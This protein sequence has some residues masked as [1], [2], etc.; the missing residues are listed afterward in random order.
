MEAFYKRVIKS[1][2]FTY[3][4]KQKDLAKFIGIKPITV[5]KALRVK[6][7][8]YDDPDKGKLNNWII[9]QIPID[10]F[11]FRSLRQATQKDI[12]FDIFDTE[13]KQSVISKCETGKTISINDLIKIANYI[14]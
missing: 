10:L 11:R 5:S 13:K 12:A 14:Y 4:M 2:L 3:K 7:I 1:Y 6:D 9:K 8:A